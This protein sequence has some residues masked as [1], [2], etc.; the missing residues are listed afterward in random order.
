MPKKEKGNIKILNKCFSA[1]STAKG[2][3]SGPLIP[4]V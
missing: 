4:T 2:G 3:P 1:K